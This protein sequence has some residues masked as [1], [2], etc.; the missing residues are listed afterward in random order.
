MAKILVF[1]DPR[2]LSKPPKAV[3]HRLASRELKNNL[4]WL[5]RL[6]RDAF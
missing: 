1:I 3:M 5:K 2:L 4:L 6:T